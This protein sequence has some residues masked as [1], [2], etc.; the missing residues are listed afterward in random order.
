MGTFTFASIARLSDYR[1]SFTTPVKQAQPVTS[2][3][4]LV[5]SKIPTGPVDARTEQALKW[6]G[7]SS[8]NSNTSSTSYN[9]P[10]LD[11]AY[12]FSSI[13]GILAYRDALVARN[14]EQTTN[15]SQDPS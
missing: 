15:P 12:S 6:S 11:L 5:S 13:K 7:L 9:A 14:S 3:I 4:P 2:S 10:D 1:N 8:S